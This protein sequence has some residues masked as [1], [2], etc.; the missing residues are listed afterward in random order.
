VLT[1]LTVTRGISPFSGSLRCESVSGLLNVVVGSCCVALGLK[2]HRLALLAFYPLVPK[3]I[4]LHARILDCHTS[5][6]IRSPTGKRGIPS[7]VSS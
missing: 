3:S 6:L 2:G 4:P 7:L 1:E 5:S